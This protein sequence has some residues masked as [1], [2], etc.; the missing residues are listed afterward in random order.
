MN[1]FELSQEQKDTIDLVCV[2]H[3]DNDFKY[4]SKMLLF[5]LINQMVEPLIKN[6][7]N[8]IELKINNIFKNFELDTATYKN[9]LHFDLQKQCRTILISR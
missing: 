3:K 5:S 4:F 7:K 1:G 6:D 2:L 8:I 9:L